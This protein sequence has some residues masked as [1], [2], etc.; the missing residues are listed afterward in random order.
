[1]KA[2]VKAKA[3][4][5]LEKKLPVRLQQEFTKYFVTKKDPSRMQFLLTFFNLEKRALPPLDL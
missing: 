1:L 3:K 4:V 2:K 5:M